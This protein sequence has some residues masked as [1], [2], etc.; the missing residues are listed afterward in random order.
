MVVYGDAELAA[1][2]PAQ[3]LKSLKWQRMR[4]AIGLLQPPLYQLNE[5]RSKI[6]ERA[7]LG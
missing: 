5:V 1:A 7:K 6:I 4:C 2:C 3:L